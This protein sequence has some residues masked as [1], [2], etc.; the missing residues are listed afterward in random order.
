V[1]SSIL[2]AAKC[3]YES[4]TGSVLFENWHLGNVGNPIAICHVGGAVS[5]ILVYVIVKIAKEISGLIIG[6]FVMSRRNVQWLYDELPEL[7]NKGVLSQEYSDKLKE[8]YGE[9]PSGS[10][11]S[12]SLTIFGILGAF[13]IGLGIILMLAHN[14][15]MLSRS[16]RTVI[17][18]VPLV[19]A[20][21][22]ALWV[23]IRRSDSTAWRE[24]VSTFFMLAIGSSLALI[25]QTYHISESTA[26][27][28]LVWMLLS[29]PL[30]YFMNVCFP[31]VLYLIGITCWS[32]FAQVEIGHAAMFWPLFALI[33]P[34]V[35]QSAK[36]NIYSN[37]TRLLFWGVAVCLCISV[38]IVMEGTIP[39]LWI[40]VYSAL[41]AGLY[42]V[43]TLLLSE[44]KNI[45][46]NPFHTIGASGIFMLSLV[47]TYEWPWKHIGWTNYRTYGGYNQLAGLLDYFLLLLLVAIAVYLLVVCVRERE[48]FRLLYGFMPVLAILAYALCGFVSDILMPIIL[49][50]IYIFILGI[51]TMIAGFRSYRVGVVNAGMAIMMILIVARFFDSDIGFILKGM[52]FVLLGIGF[53]VTNIILI[54]RKGDRK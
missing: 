53:L 10:R 46:R 43:D 29:L 40:I 23:M 39:G 21:L 24:G 52:I 2:F 33:V 3:I 7:V 20:Q 30:V 11:Q 8:Y 49:F 31:A 1:V 27:F 42:L 44:N 34:C 13:L 47:L 16:M 14:W 26:N 50:N 12:L 22:L 15:D 54:R 38:G 51:G 28:I 36:N 35:F 19:L 37:R 6:G 9:R 18:L 32:G 41:F 45:W 48:C 4:V 17:S 5:G 25:G